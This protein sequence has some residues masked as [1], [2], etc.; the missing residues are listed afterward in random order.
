MWRWYRERYRRTIDG[1]QRQRRRPR[2][3]H[4]ITGMRGHALRPQQRRGRRRP[5]L[6]VPAA[7]A[8]FISATLRRRS[9]SAV[10]VPV[11]HDCRV[12][13]ASCDC[14]PSEKPRRSFCTH[15]S[16]IH[17]TFSTKIQ[18]KANVTYLGDRRHRFKVLNQEAGPD[19]LILL[20]C[21]LCKLCV[22]V[23]CILWWVDIVW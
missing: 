23:V 1:I 6:E 16:N 2:R 3:R 10:A 19:F 17:S 22:F 18:I 5:G 8:A 9:V 21:I 7:A 4:G 12:P 15:K 11:L 20:G 13:T 14:P